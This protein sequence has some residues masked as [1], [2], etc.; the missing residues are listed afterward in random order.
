VANA[1]NV[2]IRNL[3]FQSSND[4]AIV[5]DPYHLGEGDSPAGSL[6]ARNNFFTGFGSGQTGGSV[7]SIPYSDSVDS[8]SSVKGTVTAGA[9]TGH[10]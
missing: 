3:R 6:V 7:R 4:D 10:I 2:V 5:V 9:G 1:R 8:P